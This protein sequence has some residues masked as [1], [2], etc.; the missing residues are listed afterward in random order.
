MPMFG[1][2]VLVTYAIAYETSLTLEVFTPAPKT[3]TRQCH[4]KASK[5]HSPVT[6]LESE[7]EA[8]R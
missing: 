3:Y 2:I 6:S 8:A 7:I 1:T 5:R 4:L